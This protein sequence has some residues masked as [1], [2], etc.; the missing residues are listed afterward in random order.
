MLLQP[1]VQLPIL[2]SLRIHEC[3][4]G[5]LVAAGI[6]LRQLPRVHKYSVL[7]TEPSKD[8]STYPRTRPCESSSYCQ[9][10]P[11]WLKNYPW[12][13]YSYFFDGAF[14]RACAFFAPVQAGGR[15]LGY[16]V[17]MPFRA[18]TRM[19]EKEYRCKERL[20]PYHPFQNGEV[21]CSIILLM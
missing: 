8:A 9:F 13:H 4:I 19:S 20:S 14:C 3:D 17:S 11:T 16:F 18:W 21:S 15:D 6:V 5:K 7:K 1:W 12:L 2:S 10:Q